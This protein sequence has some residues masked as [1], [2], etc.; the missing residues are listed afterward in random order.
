[1]SNRGRFGLLPVL[2]AIIFCLSCS[3][4]GCKCTEPEPVQIRMTYIFR[5]AV[6]MCMGCDPC[7]YLY[8]RFDCEAGSCT[9]L[10]HYD[11]RD[12]QEIPGWLDAVRDIEYCYDNAR[13]IPTDSSWSYCADPALTPREDAEAEE[14]ALW[15]SGSLVAPQELYELLVD[16]LALIRAGWGDSIPELNAI[17][18]QPYQ[19]SN[20][21]AVALYGDDYERFMQGEYNDLDSLN[22]LFGATDVTPWLFNSLRI[23]FS[24]RYNVWRLA[25]VYM[26]EH[27]VL[28]AEPG[29][30][31]IFICRPSTVLP[32]RLCP[33]ISNPG[34]PD[35]RN[36]VRY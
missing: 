24:A 14:A 31:Y 19:P 34:L 9:Y 5:E 33:A 30:G 13:C 12:G 18:F 17:S 1:M 23:T 2:V 26:R 36:S 32:W 27:S 10:G 3:S 6:R 22:A 7:W 4:D 35:C 11:P 25:E 28:W 16:D 21:L 15:L 20:D 29:N 8:W